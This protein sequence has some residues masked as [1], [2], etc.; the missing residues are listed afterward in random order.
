MRSLA[1]AYIKLVGVAFALIAT[2][3]LVAPARNLQVDGISFDTFPVAGRAEVQ[4]Y[5]VGTAAT[6]SYIC[7]FC[8]LSI[9]LKAIQ[10]VLGGFWGCRVVAYAL[11]GADTDPGLRFHQHT[12]FGLEILGSAVATYLLAATD[13]GRQL[14]IV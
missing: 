8:D 10:L 6:I 3:M 11:E 7:F 9:A 2:T 12:V 13:S 14:K 5:Y 1:I 4:A